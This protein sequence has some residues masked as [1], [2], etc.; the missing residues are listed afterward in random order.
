MLP[1][2]RVW[3]PP[4]GGQGGRGCFLFL[5]LR[6]LADAARHPGLVASRRGAGDERGKPLYTPYDPLHPLS[7]WWRA[8]L[9]HVVHPVH[10]S[11]LGAIGAHLPASRVICAPAAALPL[12]GD[13]LRA[14]ARWVGGMFFGMSVERRGAFPRHESSSW[15]AG[16]CPHSPGAPYQIRGKPL[17]PAPHQGTIFRHDDKYASGMT[18]TL[19]FFVAPCTSF[20]CAESATESLFFPPHQG[21]LC[22]CEEGTTIPPC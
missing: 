2:I 12:R 8:S 20:Y 18:F 21:M 16:S 5:F 13:R 17:L 6:W 10:R 22:V 4:G 19:S 15:A 7:A 3:S 1:G 14:P 9:S 11:P